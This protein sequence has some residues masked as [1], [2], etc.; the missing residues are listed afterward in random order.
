MLVDALL[1]NPLHYH[2]PMSRVFTSF[3]I[4]LNMS[5][6]LPQP[7][8]PAVPRPGTCCARFYRVFIDF[9]FSLIFDVLCTYVCSVAYATAHCQQTGFIAT[10]ALSCSTNGTRYTCVF[11]VSLTKVVV[12]SDFFFVYFVRDVA[13]AQRHDVQAHHLYY[14]AHCRLCPC[15]HCHHRP[16]LAAVSRRRRPRS[17]ILNCRRNRKSNVRRISVAIVDIIHFSLLFH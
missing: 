17:S 4:E 10:A 14:N 8:P 7:L 1:A 2:S 5:Q 15:V 6:D 3:V 11:S 16:A 13:V 12:N 9:F